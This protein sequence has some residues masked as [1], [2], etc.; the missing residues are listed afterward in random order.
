LVV[1]STGTDQSTAI[2]DLSGG[3]I[4]NGAG[5][6]ATATTN[7]TVNAEIFDR[8]TVDVTGDL[9]VM[10]TSNIGGASLT[11]GGGVGI[12]ADVNESLANV[13][14]TPSVNTDIGQSVTLVAGGTITVESLHGRVPSPVSDG[15]FNPSQVNETPILANV[16]YADPATNQITLS[17]SDVALYTGEPIVYDAASGTM[18][19]GLTNGKTYYA[20]P[21]GIPGVIQVASSL[22]NANDGKA[23]T[24][25]S[26]GAGTFVLPDNEITFTMPDGL[27]TGNIVT[28]SQNGNSAIGG[29]TNGRVYQVITVPGNDNS[30]QLGSSFDAAQVDT[31]DDTIVF[32]SDDNLENGDLV[33]YEDNGGTP[34]GGLT[35]G[36]LYQVFVINSNTIKLQD[37]SA[38]SG[39]YHT[40]SF[41][42]E[43]TVDTNANY[44]NSIHLSGFKD[45]DAVTYNAP[46]PVEASGLQVTPKNE[47][48]LAIDANGN[49]ISDPIPDNFQNGDPVVYTVAPGGTPIGGLV[50]GQT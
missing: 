31:V 7:P 46:A 6:N 37:P 19:N 9:N 45:G 26:F 33:I 36:Q 12:I 5:G 42:P 25:K 27:M 15:T 50:P 18:I 48:N 35:P 11:K 40:S 10:G 16:T 38:R 47:I 34:I 4:F 29:L 41:D 24:L 2:V 44:P 20:I 30:L 13:S 49:K 17:P 22:S 14:L 21:T 3:G 8:A 1:T 23:I 39:T 43:K 32:P 28:Y